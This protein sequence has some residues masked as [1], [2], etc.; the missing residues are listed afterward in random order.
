M[1]GTATTLT[2]EQTADLLA[3]AYDRDRDL[4]RWAL[5]W[6]DGVSGLTIDPDSEEVYRLGDYCVADIGWA[7][8]QDDPPS[9]GRC[10]AEEEWRQAWLSE[11]GGETGGEVEGW[12]YVPAWETWSGDMTQRD[13]MELSVY[14]PSSA[15]I[16]DLEASG[17][18][19][20]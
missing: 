12:S 18:P 4:Y 9:L 20:I 10:A 5:A 14:V 15:E 16:E 6:L 13:R 7:R 2:A 3:Q 17:Q 19:V 11:A 8:Y 1:T